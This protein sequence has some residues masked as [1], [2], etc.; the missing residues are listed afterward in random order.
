MCFHPAAR[1]R[2]KPRLAE[3]LS[4]GHDHLPR[5][6][7]ELSLATGEASERG[8]SAAGFRAEGGRRFRAGG[9]FDVCV[10]VCVCLFL[11]FG[12]AM[13]EENQTGNMTLF[14]RQ[15][16]CVCLC[17]LVFIFGV[18][19]SV[20]WFSRFFRLMPGFMVIDPLTRS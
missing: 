19:V 10:C 8:I 11:C 3:A 4:L 18:C 20:C 13:W 2:L 14:P 1:A 17:V 12:K 16:V 5:K 15:C 6:A 7:L 9:W